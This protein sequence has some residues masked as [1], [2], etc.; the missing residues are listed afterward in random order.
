MR[1]HLKSLYYWSIPLL[2]RLSSC[3]GVD[4]IVCSHGGVGTTFISE[5]ISRYLR[6]NDPYDCDHSK[7]IP[8]PPRWI[9]R[10]IR[11]IYV[12]GN[13]REAAMSLFAR[14][15]AGLQSCKNGIIFPVEKNES[16]EQYL[17]RGEDR[18]GLTDHLSRWIN[19]RNHR[20]DVLLVKYDKLWENAATI[21]SF[22][23]IDSK[24]IDLF[25][26]RKTRKSILSDLSKRQTVQLCQMYERY[27]AIERS[28]DDVQI[29]HKT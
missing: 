9:S 13:P 12:Y 24:S 18:L 22:L 6:A 26:E 17:E 16:F 28:M 10:D 4:V 14:G 15:Y 29:F 2:T 3:Q 27:T 7:H 19:P 1:S 11:I 5:F 25:P 8:I 23:G 20:N 21:I